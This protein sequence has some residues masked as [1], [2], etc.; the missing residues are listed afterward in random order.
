[1]ITVGKLSYCCERV[2]GQGTFSTVFAGLFE[3]CK[4][5]AIKRI[6]KSYDVK[7]ESQLKR[8]I[9]LMLK[10]NDHPNILRLFCCEMTVDFMYVIIKLMYNLN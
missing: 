4:P 10:M 7:S 9:E 2:I 3:E 1:M 8:E 5:V 6:Q